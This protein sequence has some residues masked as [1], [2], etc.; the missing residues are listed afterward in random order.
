MTQLSCHSYLLTGFYG[1]FAYS[2]PL[3]KDFDYFWRLDSNVR[4]LCVPP[5]D[6]AQYVI[7]NDL[8]Y[9]KTLPK[10]FVNPI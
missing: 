5:F 4:Y 10:Q 1:G 9:G 3:L 6:P 8:D 7:D 2:H